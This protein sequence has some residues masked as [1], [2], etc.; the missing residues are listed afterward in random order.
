MFTKPLCFFYSCDRP[1]DFDED[2]ELFLF[3]EALSEV[4]EIADMD[5]D[6]KIKLQD[7]LR[8]SIHF[9]LK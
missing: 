3:E 6:G 1:D 5:K 2:K 7:F 8:V 9:I 4:F